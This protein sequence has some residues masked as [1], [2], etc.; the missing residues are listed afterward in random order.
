MRSSSVLSTTVGGDNRRRSQQHGRRLVPSALAV[1]SP[2]LYYRTGKQLPTVQS[3]SIKMKADQKPLPPCLS[4]S[5]M[6]CLHDRRSSDLISRRTRGVLGEREVFNSVRGVSKLGW[7]KQLTYYV[8]SSTVH[9]HCKI[10]KDSPQLGAGNRRR[11]P[12]PGRT[13]TG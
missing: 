5:S 10:V 11:N 13:T 3:E 9:R 1:L 12:I 6:I 7:L 4:H 2:F 8:L